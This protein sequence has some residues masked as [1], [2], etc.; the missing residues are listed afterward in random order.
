[1]RKNFKSRS[2]AALALLLSLVPWTG[3]CNHATQQQEQFDLVLITIDTIRADHIGSYGYFRDTS[4]N[5]DAFSNESLLFERCL[6]PMATT[7]PSHVSILTSVHP[8]E[9]GVL[10]NIQQVGQRFQ[11][12]EQLRSF[13][14]VASEAGYRTAAF[15]SGAPLNRQT[16]I[17]SGFEDFDQPA[18]RERP[19]EETNQAVFH[20]L[21]KE[22]ERPFFLWVHYFDPHAPYNPPPSFRNLYE[23]DQALETY[24][25]R[26][27]FSDQAVSPVGDLVNAREAINLYDGEIRYVDEQVGAL[28]NHLRSRTKW[29]RT[30]VALVGDHGEGLCQHAE[31]RH[32]YIYDEQLHVPLMIRVPNVPHRRISSLVSTIDVLPTVLGFSKSEFSREFLQ[33][34]RGRNVMSEEFNTQT[35]F[36]QSTAKKRADHSFPTY[37]L[38][39]KEWKYIHEVGGSDR[40]FR[41]SEDPFELRDELTSHAAIGSELREQLLAQISEQLENGRAVYRS[42]QVKKTETVDPILI[43]QLKALGYTN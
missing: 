42:G 9:H 40:L 21:M 27:G 2:P 32:G 26:R 12:S 30:I 37:A 35:V 8:L 34:A 3:S 5:I 15:V 19:A 43:E 18:E 33:Q 6:V 7:L 13:A 10:A 4:P 14:E 11:P 29:D 41:L 17:D 23:S 36:S 28:L 24:L 31:P 16:G 39:T 25:A 1:M 22:D 38:T 20:W